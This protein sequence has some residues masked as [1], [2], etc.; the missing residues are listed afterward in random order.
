MSERE[1]NEKRK[2][3]VDKLAGLVHSTVKN[4]AV[5]QQ[6][7]ASEE[8]PGPKEPETK[9]TVP[10]QA[11]ATQEGPGPKEP[12]TN[13]AA[14]QQ[15]DTSEEGPGP[16]EP[17]TNATA[18]QQ[19]D[20]SQEGP[21]PKGPETN[22]TAP[23]QADTSQEGPGP[24]EPETKAA[25]PQQADASQEGPGPKEAK[26]AKEAKR[27]E[28]ANIERIRQLVAL[29]TDA[30]DADGPTADQKIIALA[31][32]LSER[33]R[34][35]LRAAAA[36]IK[37][38]EDRMKVVLDQF[39][40]RIVTFHDLLA[41]TLKAGNSQKALERAHTTLDAIQMSYWDRFVG[42][43]NETCQDK[44]TDTRRKIEATLEVESAKFSRQIAAIFDKSIRGLPAG[45]LQQRLSRERRLLAAALVLG[46]VL[47]SLFGVMGHTLWNN[48]GV[49]TRQ[50]L[51]GLGPFVLP[52]SDRIAR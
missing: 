36:K 37:H 5:P 49:G 30:I 44:L 39:T 42:R 16:K 12:E 19:A 6:A 32:N 20:A 52:L 9:A 13:A 28:A 26:E 14:P 33:K 48:P 38:D 34:S 22:A 24:K 11:D 4:A 29:L 50:A 7:D 43:V 15:A 40:D 46:L 10:Q 35:L 8:G 27:R 1:T 21:G 3:P 23:Q 25:V 18:P 17:E 51:R 47:G 2:I 45:T 41:K 31:R